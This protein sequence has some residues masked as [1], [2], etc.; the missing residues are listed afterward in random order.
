MATGIARTLLW[1]KRGWNEQ[2]ELGEKE[3]RKES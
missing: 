1:P 2:R 3:V